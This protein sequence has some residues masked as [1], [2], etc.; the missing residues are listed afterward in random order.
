MDDTRERLAAYAHDAWAG[1]MEY[2][3]SKCT[4]NDDGTVTIPA[5][6]VTRWQRQMQTPYADLPEMEKESDRTEAATMIVIMHG[7]PTHPT[8]QGSA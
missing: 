4:H 8:T 6:A 5:W 2:L 1:W 7:Q 3:F